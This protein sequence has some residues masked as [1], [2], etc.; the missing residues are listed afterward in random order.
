M[1]KEIKEEGFDNPF[2]GS[3]RQT[4]STKTWQES[5][6]INRKIRK[7]RLGSCKRELSN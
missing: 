7:N 5:P 1:L 3:E 4:K 6:K 2:T